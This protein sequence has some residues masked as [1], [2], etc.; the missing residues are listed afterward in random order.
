MASAIIDYSLLATE[1][2]GAVQLTYNAE[3]PSTAIPMNVRVV[4]KDGKVLLS[5]PQQIVLP[6]T[7]IATVELATLP[8]GRYYLELSDKDNAQPERVTLVV[9]DKKTIHIGEQ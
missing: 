2:T 3:Q 1:K 9:A 4:N 6:N 7:K 8:V 5:L